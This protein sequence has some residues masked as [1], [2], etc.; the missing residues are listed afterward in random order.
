MANNRK[1]QLDALG[2]PTDP[3]RIEN[4]MS[5]QLQGDLQAGPQLPAMDNFE[6]SPASSSTGSGNRFDDISRLLLGETIDELAASGKKNY[7][8]LPQGSRHH[9]QAAENV[10]SK[11]SLINPAVGT[12]SANLLGAWVE[13]VEAARGNK[14][15]SED[16]LNDLMAN[17]QGSIRGPVP[18][19]ALSAMLESLEGTDPW[20]AATPDKFE[21]VTAQMNALR[22][23]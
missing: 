10:S 16:T 21:D 15:F 22:K 7:P 19:E 23:P 20:E 17:L 5:H 12:I 6:R 14:L 3:L 11:L 1:A 2:G 18:I 4:Q 13:A 9:A 8:N